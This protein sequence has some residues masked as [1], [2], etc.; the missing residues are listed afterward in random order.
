MSN[1]RYDKCI[2]WLVEGVYFLLWEY[3]F[4]VDILIK[5]W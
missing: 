2:R 3:S 4:D 5:E 1:F